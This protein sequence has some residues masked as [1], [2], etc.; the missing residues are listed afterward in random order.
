MKLSIVIACFNASLTIKRTLLSLVGQKENEVEIIIVDDFSTDNTVKIIKDFQEEYSNISLLSLVTNIGPGAARNIAIKKAIGEYIMVIDADDEMES[1]AISYFIEELIATKYDIYKF[2]YYYRNEQSNWTSEIQKTQLQPGLYEGIECEKFCRDNFYICA[3]LWRREF[4]IE[5]NISYAEGIFYEDIEFALKG[6]TSA[7]S[8]YYQDRSLLIIHT[9]KLSATRTRFESDYHIYSLEQAMINVFRKVTFRNPIEQY[10]TWNVLLKKSIEYSMKKVPDG[11]QEKSLNRLLKVLLLN[12]QPAMWGPYDLYSQIREEIITNPKQI[13][14]IYQ[15]GFKHPRFVNPLYK[16]VLQQKVV[17]KGLQ[18]LTK[19]SSKFAY[20]LYF[21]R[22]IQK[23]IIVFQGFDYRYTGNSRY[24]FEKMIK[25]NSNKKIF[26]ITNDK[27]VTQN[28]RITPYSIEHHFLLARA[29]TVYLESWSEKQFAVGKNVK[30][31]QLWHGVPIKKLLN[32]SNDTIALELNSE[33]KIAKNKQIKRWD[34][35]FIPEETFFDIAQSAFLIP[36][37]KLTKQVYPRVEWLKKL[38]SVEF[39]SMYK[40]AYDIPLDKKIIFYAPTWRDYWGTSYDNNEN[41]LLSVDFFSNLYQEAI[42]IVYSQSKPIVNVTVKSDK[43]NYNFKI[44]NKVCIFQFFTPDEYHINI[45]FEDFSNFNGNISVSNEEFNE[46][47]YEKKIFNLSN[48]SLMTKEKILF[49]NSDFYFIYKPHPFKTSP[50]IENLLPFVKL[51]EA[52]TQ[53]LILLSDI[54]ITDYSSI[55]FDFIQ[56]NKP[57][58]F[59][60][61][62]EELYE[63]LKGVY[64]QMKQRFKHHIFYD[65]VDLLNAIAQNEGGN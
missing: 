1:N 28:Y 46:K 55:A 13:F 4:L 63:N 34:K 7:N 23:N 37:S 12:K 35:F 31:I 25:E 43:E 14:Q 58:Y 64:P 44:N 5:N 42:E 18:I 48:N 29:R 3:R 62:D 17:L 45:D 57:V 47:I 20:T 32:D 10:H 19:N 59:Y 16:K 15:K 54:C 38:R 41:P 30:L 11:M 6:Y 50:N 21:D 39:I 26:Y 33:Y 27:R 2:N 56:T 60:W 24:L 36:D 51:S 61:K 53:V 52:E 22:L 65:E 49:N 40:L 9:H 8:I